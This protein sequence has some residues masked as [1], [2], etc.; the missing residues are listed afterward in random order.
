MASTSPARIDDELYASAKLVGE[1]MSRSAAQQV[2][3]WA[4]IGREIEA[5]AGTSTQ[6]ITQVLAGR[7]RYD[8]LSTDEQAVVR[9]VWAERI[10]DEREGLDLAADFAESGQAYAELDDD[11]HVALVE[12]ESNAPVN[13]LF[14]EDDLPSI[15]RDRVVVGGLVCT[16]LGAV[17]ATGLRETRDVDELLRLD[18]GLYEVT[19]L[20]RKPGEFAIHVVPGGPRRL[21]ETH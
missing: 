19:L 10:A 6:A 17:E 3:H 16:L 4:R 20:R 2:N 9:S 13:D 21:D 5:A 1:V 7:Q 15:V 14:E 11:G 18:E 12:R 8:D